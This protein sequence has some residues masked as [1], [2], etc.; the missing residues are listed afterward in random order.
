MT[1]RPLQVSRAIWPI[2]VSAHEGG[3]TVADA[4]KMCK[5]K[6]WCCT[7]DQVVVVSGVHS[8][9]KGATDTLK[10]LDVE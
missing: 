5:A 3:K 7:G 10:I 9:R 4:I 6:N 2:V 8:M 1:W